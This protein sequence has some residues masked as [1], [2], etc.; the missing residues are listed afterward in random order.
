[1]AGSG[2]GYRKEALVTTK[3]LAKLGLALFVGTAIAFPAGMMVAGSQ[4]GSDRAR[5]AVRRD[6]AAMRDMFS[7]SV[8][9]D[10]WFA[11]RQR[12]GVEALERYCA[13]TGQSCPE[14]RAARHA[15]AEMD[16]AD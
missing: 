4:T 5:P 6:T 12:A 7:P 9:Q 16:T 8:R 3:E 13:Q 1:M 11:E 2:T 15:L 10:P 14:A